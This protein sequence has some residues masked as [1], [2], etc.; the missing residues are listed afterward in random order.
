MTPNRK[1]LAILLPLAAIG[2]AQASGF[3]RF[4][5]GGRGTAELGAFTARADEPASMSCNPAAIGKLGGVQ[6]QGGLDMSAPVDDYESPSGSFGAKHTIQFPPSL[7]AS[8]HLSD[9]RQPFA[10]GIGI[11][12]PY[13]YA[14]DWTTTVF[15]GR[16]LTRETEI[17]LFEIHPVVAFELS[18]HV[19]VG[20]GV[21]YV[22]GSF[23]LGE[24]A[25]V[26]VDSL[27]GPTS[28]EVARL[29]DASVD[30]FGLDAGIQAGGKRAGFGASYRS[31]VDLDGDGD[32]G[33]RAFNVPDDPV[34]AASLAHALRGNAAAL[35]LSL[36]A[37]VRLGAWWEPWEDIALEIDAV[38]GQWSSFDDEARYEADPFPDTGR[39]RDW[40]DTVSVRLATEVALT[41][42]WRV[43]GGLGH[44]PTPVSDDSLEPGFPRADAYLV[45]AGFGY[46]A[47]R[48]RFD[49][50]YSLHI[51]DD[52]DALAQEPDP[53]VSGTY[54]A[55]DQVFAFSITWRNE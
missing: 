23:A 27:G 48:F 25:Y 22:R 21:R 42:A 33:Y 13:W 37:E 47:E 24:N 4:Q 54:S 35:E 39:R 45:G 53:A 30:G 6:V 38:W 5:H 20:A 44:E 14:Q 8:W 11:D 1:V 52:R 34:L 50:G 51:H 32:V 40:D 46:D 10:F 19:R 18:E 26:G 16:F 31:G 43:Y 41:R 3:F 36:P 49:V 12:S 29:A 28:I 17:T 7:Y 2:N 15:P 9:D 55:V